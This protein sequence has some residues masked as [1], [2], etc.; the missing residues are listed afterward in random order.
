MAGSGRANFDVLVR[1]IEAD[2]VRTARL[3]SAE[4]EALAEH[5][6]HSYVELLDS[7]RQPASHGLT[8]RS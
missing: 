6:A 8:E 2:P 3:A 7:D 1:P 5:L 4:A